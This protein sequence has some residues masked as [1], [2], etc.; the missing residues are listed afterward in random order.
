MFWSKEEFRT[1]IWH[2][3]ITC[4]ITQKVVLLVLVLRVRWKNTIKIEKK[5]VKK[6]YYLDL[7]NEGSR[8]GGLGQGD[9]F[10]LVCGSLSGVL[11]LL[12]TMSL[13]GFGQSHKH[14]VGRCSGVHPR[15]EAEREEW[16]DGC[17]VRPTYC[18]VYVI[19]RLIG[20]YYWGGRTAGCPTLSA[21]GG[22]T[23]RLQFSPFLQRRRA[24]AVKTRRLSDYMAHLTL[25][26]CDT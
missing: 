17:F 1:V 4:K 5:I 24:R 20:L 9:G 15:E 6:R 19:W 18:W 14:H 2:T 21:K 16:N 23:T 7:L 3:K 8:R 13:D 12:R 11:A 26:P 10:E 25:S 22:T